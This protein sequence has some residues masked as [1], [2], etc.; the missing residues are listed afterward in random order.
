M[1]RRVSVTYLDGNRV[2]FGLQRKHVIY[3]N[4]F[5]F[6]CQFYKVKNIDLDKSFDILLLAFFNL[7]R[8]SISS[9]KNRKGEK[10]IWFSRPDNWVELNRVKNQIE[11]VGLQAYVRGTKS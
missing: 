6:K 1:R 9:F 7:S 11:M 3:I 2:N 10:R 4:F 8:S 5:R